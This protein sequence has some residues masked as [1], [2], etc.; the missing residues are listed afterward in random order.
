M[1]QGEWGTVTVEPSDEYCQGLPQGQGYKRMD[2]D[3]SQTPQARNS[4]AWI[5]GPEPLRLDALP[6]GMRF[7]YRRASP[8]LLPQEGTTIACT[9]VGPHPVSL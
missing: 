6:L 2:C 5:R 1:R 4:P 8:S 3:A 7:V 9:S